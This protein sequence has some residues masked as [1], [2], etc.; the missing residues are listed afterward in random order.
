MFMEADMTGN[1]N[2]MRCNVK[3]SITKMNENPIY[4]YYMD[5]EKENRDTKGTQ[6]MIIRRLLK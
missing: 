6:K 5:V 3:T 4:D 1:I 2:T